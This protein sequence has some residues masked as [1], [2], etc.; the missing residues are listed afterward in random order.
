MA[1]KHFLDSLLWNPMPSACHQKKL[2]SYLLFYNDYKK[3][4]TKNYKNGKE[5]ILFIF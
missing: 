2:S 3:N 1:Q 5:N 4:K